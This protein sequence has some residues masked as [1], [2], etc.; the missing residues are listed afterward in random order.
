MWMGGCGKS[1]VKM[2]VEKVLVKGR[3]RRGKKKRFLVDPV[4]M[5]VC[6][7]VCESLYS[8]TLLRL[9][10]TCFALPSPSKL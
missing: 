7:F 3:G 1:E 8:W 6:V 2:R 10:S 5:H 4:C 9:P